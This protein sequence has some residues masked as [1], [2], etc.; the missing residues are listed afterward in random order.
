M[1]VQKLHSVDDAAIN[2]LGKNAI[3]STHKI[4]NLKKNSKLSNW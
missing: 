1:T 3:K 2:W 4:I